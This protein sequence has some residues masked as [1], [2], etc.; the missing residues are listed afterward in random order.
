MSSLGAL[1]GLKRLELVRCSSLTD[2]GLS[3]LKDLPI[4]FLKLR[5]FADITW[6]G[7]QS[8]KHC[9]IQTVDITGCEQLPVAVVANLLKETLK[10]DET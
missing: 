1:A 10:E 7:I 3:F 6:V 5:W 8:L 4:E 2:E 9:P